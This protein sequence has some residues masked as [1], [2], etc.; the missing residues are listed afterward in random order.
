VGSRYGSPSGSIS[1]GKIRIQW[2]N[3]GEGVDCEICPST[4]D[5]GPLPIDFL[6]D[7]EASQKDYLLDRYLNNSR[8]DVSIVL[9]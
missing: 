9:F 4:N 5:F 8:S 6:F 7:V 1:K 2:V 3:G